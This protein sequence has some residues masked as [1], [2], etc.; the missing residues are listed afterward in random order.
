MI[1]L[2]FKLLNFQISHNVQGM[3]RSGHLTKTMWSIVIQSPECGAAHVT[4]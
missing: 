2:I 3:Q 1:F 4:E